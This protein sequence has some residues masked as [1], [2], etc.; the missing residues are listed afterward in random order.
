MITRAVQRSSP[1]AKG[2][3][4]AGAERFNRLF[5]KNQNVFDFLDLVKFPLDPF[6]ARS[7]WSPSQLRVCLGWLVRF[8]DRCSAGGHRVLR[9]ARCI[10]SPRAK[11]FDVQHSTQRCDRVVSC[12]VFLQ[13]NASC[14]FRKP[15]APFSPGKCMMVSWTGSGLTL[16]SRKEHGHTTLGSLNRLRTDLSVNARVA[17]PQ[18][19]GS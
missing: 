15:R 2:R 3:T 9:Q 18:G 11:L 4:A 16:W 10:S 13:A 5:K 1:R 7:I 12:C 14:S 6:S 19:Q 17:A 8:V